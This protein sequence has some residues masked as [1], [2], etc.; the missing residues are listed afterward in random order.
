MARLQLRGLLVGLA[1][2]LVATLTSAQVEIQ[3]TIKD[4]NTAEALFGATVLDLDSEAGTTTGLDGEFSLRVAELPARIRVSYVGYL[5]LEMTVAGQLPIELYLESDAVQLGDVVVTG[6]G[7]K[8]QKRE[9]GYSTDNVSGEQLALSNAPNVINALSG[10]SAGVQ[11]VSPNGVDGGTTRIVIRGNNNL[12]GNNQPLIIVDGVPIE[13]P[14]G[15]TDIGRGVD[16]GSAINNI[17]AE[18]IQDVS[19]LKGPTA[20]AKY[21][22]RG[23]N[24]VVLITTKKGAVTKGLGVEYIFT[25]KVITPFRYR[26]VQNK[27]GAGGPISL[28]EPAFETNA[29]GELVYPRDV[30]SNN[31]PFG[32]PTTEQFG[33]YSTGVSWGPEMRGQMV[34]WWDGELRDYSPQPDN[35]QQFFQNGTTNTHNI[36]LSKGGEFGSIRTSLTY[37]DHEA[38]VPNSNFEQYT[39]NIGS[40]LKI[41]DRV[42]AEL[43]ISYIKFSRKNSPSLGDD[44][45]ASF[46]K[47]I[48]Y[49]WPRS[50]KGLERA[51]N[52]NPDGTRYNYDGNYPF[53]FTPQHLWWNT[54]NQNTYLDRNKF[55]GSVG[56][57]YQVTDWLV[58]TARTGIDYTTNEFETRNNPVDL[59]GINEARYARELD[60]NIVHNSEA[61]LTA[62]KRNALNLFDVSLSLGGARWHRDQY[63]L[64]ASTDQWVNPWLFAFSNY[65]GQ[66]LNRIPVAQE[67]RFEKKIN[68]VFSF[69]NLSYDNTIFLELSGRN[70]WSSA[71]P[72][73]NNSYFYPSASLSY[74]LSEHLNLERLPVDF[75]KL[76][77]AYAKTANDTDPYQL[78]FIYNINTFNGNQ[79]A[80]LPN[81]RPPSEL[82]PQQADSYEAGLTIGLFDSK[83]NVD[84]TYYQIESFDQ[85]LESP[86]PTSSGVSAVRINNGVLENRGFECA[87]NYNV[88]SKPNGYLKAGLNFSSNQNTV[89]SLGDGAQILEIGDIWGDFG[90]KIMV[91]EGQ[92]YGTIYGYDYVRHEGTGQPILNE[93]GTHYQITDNLVPVGN[94][95]PR[96]IGGFTLQGR[97][98]NFTFSALVDTRIGGDIYAGSYVIGLQTGQ[99]PETLAE[100][101]G[102]GLP[103]TDPDGVTRNVGVILP[104][105]YADGTPNDKVVHYY[106]KYLPNAGGWGKILTTPGILENTWVKMREFS[107]NY[108]FPSKITSKLRIL[109]N[110]NLS[111]VGRD[112]FYFYSAL[113]DN[114]NPEGAG[115][116]GNAQGLEWA[117]FPS[118]RSISF[119]LAAKF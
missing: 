104:G 112:L 14:P 81:T 106:H 111:L 62:T 102:E 15:L 85:I 92:A 32:R 50:Y 23:A 117:S 107:I 90:P 79:T 96:L 35:L 100:R 38:V 77:L 26:K 118:M 45:N 119:R 105:V 36:A 51:L 4:K 39:A 66:D 34:R 75:L 72:V 43:S 94:S 97:Y 83:I 78:D 56:L 116:A 60:Q 5:D 69:L 3:G 76:R 48:L 49:S 88:L 41:S 24:G 28:S 93:A 12:T 98:K 16:W 42:G 59:F 54:F 44:N 74:V 40:Q 70:D 21:G 65:S 115:G 19:I 113:P 7:I 33:F 55:I 87:I 25:T 6:L 84:F 71:L 52:I 80:S 30:H 108:D 11:V 10:R 63:G 58:A 61:L 99:S 101:E 9:L 20:S 95:A 91:Q 67:I 57:N 22:M 13:N 17:N 68:S 89:V 47:G 64:N 114:I 18:D 46:G 37:Q 8:R 29:D 73:D 31:G 27:Y 82:R 86:V 1:L 2:L 53:Q 110:L 103:Y 109:Q